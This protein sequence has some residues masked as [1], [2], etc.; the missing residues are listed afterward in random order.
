VTVTV[1]PRMCMFRTWNGLQN[2]V[3]KSILLGNLKNCAVTLT[4]TIEAYRVR[5]PPEWSKFQIQLFAIWTVTRIS[6]VCGP[7]KQSSDLN[8]VGRVGF[9]LVNPGPG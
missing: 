1:K 3:H 4:V 5:R 9:N 8:P 6:K 7:S 2:I